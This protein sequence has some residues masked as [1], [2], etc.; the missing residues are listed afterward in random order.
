MNRLF[1]FSSLLFFILGCASN[2]EATT[3]SIKS[4]SANQ[5]IKQASQQHSDFE[6]FTAKLGGEVSING[7]KTPIS[8]NL[9]IKKDSL[10]WISVSALFGIEVARIQL[11]TDSLKFINRINKVYWTGS[12]DEA[13]QFLGLSTNYKQLEGAVTGSLILSTSSWKS[14]V[15]DN[16]YVLQSKNNNDRSTKVIFDKRFLTHSFFMQD[17]LEQSFSVDYF[18]YEQHELGWFPSK[19]ELFLNAVNQQI[20]A[21]INYSRIGVDTP[22]K[23][24][25]NIPQSY[26]RMD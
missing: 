8:A 5:I 14:F 7:T 2:K 22:V 13:V 3:Y 18:D 10:M 4:F 24:N 11:T 6:W 20:L 16:K 21:S 15:L 9:R 26:D 17:H 1:A 25:F 12:Y 23:V 19:I